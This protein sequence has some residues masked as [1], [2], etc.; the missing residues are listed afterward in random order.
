MDEKTLMELREKMRIERERKLRMDFM[1]FLHEKGL[2]TVDEELLKVAKNA[3]PV[4]KENPMDGEIAIGASKIGGYPDLPPEIDYPTLCAYTENRGNKST[5]YEESAMQLVA[6][7]NLSDVAEFD[8]DNVLPKSG[9]IWIFWSGELPFYDS[10]FCT[11]SFEGKNRETYKVL[12]YDGNLEN[13]KRTKPAIPYYSKYF[14][15]PFDEAKMK[16]EYSKNEYNI[17]DLEEELGEWYE[18]YEGN[19]NLSSNKLLGYPVGSMNISG[20][21]D[22]YVSIFQYDYNVGCLWNLYWYIKEEDLKAGDFTKVI[23]DFDM[24]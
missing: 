11:Y 18:Y 24:D 5:H 17:E 1:E 3:I 12:Y 15:E 20:L 22:G 16:F 7:I 21:Q 2:V 8:K 4:F 10:R 9:I 23:M 19:Y 13:L 6:Q 14:E